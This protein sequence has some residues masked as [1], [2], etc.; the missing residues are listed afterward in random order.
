[1]TDS[2]I[3]GMVRSGA[4]CDIV[5]GTEVLSIGR[6]A[7]SQED[8][9]MELSGRQLLFRIALRGGWIWISACGMDE[10]DLPQFLFNIADGPSGWTTVRKF[11]QALE[12]SGVTSL[13][14]RPITIGTPGSPD[15]FVIG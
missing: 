11:V 2:G 4:W 3:S 13:K 7:D 8:C 12:R 1:M 9:A 5:V 15:C 10:P 14:E 6:S